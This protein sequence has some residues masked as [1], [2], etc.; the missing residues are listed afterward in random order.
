[1][2]FTNFETREIHFKILYTG[3]HGAGKTENLRT[4]LRSTLPQ[5]RHIKFAAPNRYPLCFEF[6]PLTL[7]QIED[8]SLH[9]HLFAVPPAVPFPTV[10]ET[11]Y[12]GV[13]GFVFVADSRF[14]CMVENLRVWQEVTQ[15]FTALGVSMADFPHLIQYNKRD[16]QDCLPLETLQ[17]ALNTQES[18]YCETIAT[19]SVGVAD[20]LVQITKRVLEKVR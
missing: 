9:I 19:Q 18:P 3:P 17:Q 6:L 16:A 7:G 15:R 8:F 14:P 13:D 2:A 5:P 10:A 11:L 1:M 12:H 20:T 4:L